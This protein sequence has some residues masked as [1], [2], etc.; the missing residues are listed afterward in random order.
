MISRTSADA[1]GDL[2]RGFPIVAVTGPRQAGK[3]TLVRQTFANLPYVSLEDPDRLERVLDDPRGFLDRYRDGVVLDEAQRCPILFSYLQSHV[4]ATRRLGRVVLTGSQQFG[5]MAGITQTLAGRVGLVELLPLSVAELRGAALLADDLDVQLTTGGYPAIYDRGLQP[6]LW[7]ANYVRT[8]VERDVRQALRVQDLGTF[9]RF[10]RLCAG[11]VGQ[12]LNLSSLANDCGIT[13]PTAAAWISVLQASYVAFLLPPHHRNFNKRLIK[14]P[15]LYFYDSGLAAWLLGIQEPQQLTT[16]P[17]R[18]ALFENLIVSELVKAR[19][20]RG[21][22][23]NLY[24]WRDRSGNEIDVLIE[25]ADKLYPIEVKAGQTVKREM[26]QTL[27]RWQ[28]IAGPAAG[29]ARLVYGGSERERLGEID[30]LSWR[31]VDELTR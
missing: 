3:S 30:V 1:L 6:V 2:A 28:A 18:G 29:P 23:S 17:L 27:K 10:L 26:V 5:L 4:D 16:H 21:L 14:T 15:K 7:F 31:T 19:F 24:F 9:Q 13:H 20:H 8:Y 11:R 22:P 25:V 12:L